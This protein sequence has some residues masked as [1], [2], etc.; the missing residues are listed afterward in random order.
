[1]IIP[2]V[3]VFLAVFFFVVVVPECTDTRPS[4]EPSDFQR[5]DMG[6]CL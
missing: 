3:S 6:S 4:A 1:M 2:A 5:K